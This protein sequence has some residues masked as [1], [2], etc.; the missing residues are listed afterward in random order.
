MIYEILSDEISLLRLNAIFGDNFGYM[1]EIFYEQIMK[2][3]NR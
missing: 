3:L 1:F 2:E